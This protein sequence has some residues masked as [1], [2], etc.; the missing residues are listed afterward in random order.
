MLEFKNISFKLGKKQLLKDI[1][2]KLEYGDKL[3]ILGPNGASKSTLLRAIL[4][5][6][7]LKGEYYLHSKKANF[8]NF[9]KHFSYVAQSAKINLP[10]TL[11]EV[12]LMGNY[13]N[14]KGLFY[15]QD[16][17]K[18]AL[19]A[20]LLLDLAHLS[21]RTFSTLSGGEQQLGLIARALCK[22]SDILVLDEPSSAL[23]LSFTNKLFKLLLNLNLKGLVFTTHDPSQAS[24]ASKVLML[25]NGS[26]HAFG[27]TR[28]LLCEEKINS[29]YGIDSKLVCLPNGTRLFYQ[30][31]FK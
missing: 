19:N 31:I 5:F 24:I 29:L 9:Y 15:T 3:C 14:S 22:N 1:S 28:T 16:D 10:Y 30:D 4:G 25:K 13:P 17:K 26:V 12:V 2:F 27:P 7:P 23:D 20:L 6:L 11:F 21:S 8:A 18:R